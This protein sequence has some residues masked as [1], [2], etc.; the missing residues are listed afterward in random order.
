VSGEKGL[1]GKGNLEGENGARIFK[2]RCITNFS[3]RESNRASLRDLVKM[4]TPARKIRSETTPT[5]ESWSYY[6]DYLP[7]GAQK[8]GEKVGGYTIREMEGRVR[9][10]SFFG[11]EPLRDNRNSEN[12]IR[13]LPQRERGG[14][15]ECRG[16]RYP[17]FGYFNGS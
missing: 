4:K 13:G 3:R 9:S 17:R 10:V 11:V 15:R 8:V 14:G 16:Q 12:L 7:K 2:N 1:D 5:I 6:E